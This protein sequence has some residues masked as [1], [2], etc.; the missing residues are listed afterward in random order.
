MSGTI[1]SYWCTQQLTHFNYI[2][3]NSNIPVPKKKKKLSK[4]HL[5][6]GDKELMKKTSI[7]MNIL[8]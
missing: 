2:N 6:Y 4:Q 7:I 8:S 5:C 1:I 3:T